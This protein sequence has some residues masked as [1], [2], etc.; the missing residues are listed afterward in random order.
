LTS[1]QAGLQAS[2]QQLESHIGSLEEQLVQTRHGQA[3]FATVQ[4]NLNTNTH[5]LGQTQSELSQLKT[6]LQ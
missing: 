4:A 3:D 5:Q 1:Q 6:E 2:I